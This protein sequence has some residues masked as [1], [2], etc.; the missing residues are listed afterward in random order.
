MQ[1]CRE[2]TPRNKSCFRDKVKR[3]AETIGARRVGILAQKIITL[4]PK[5]GCK[6]LLP[7]MENFSEKIS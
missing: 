1:N 2:T 4:R 7:E 6:F 3:L 5:P